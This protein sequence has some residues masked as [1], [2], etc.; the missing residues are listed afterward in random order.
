[1][2][3]T[4]LEQ[5]M[6][7]LVN[8]ARMD[9]MGDA[10]RYISGYAPLTSAQSNIQSAL[11]YFGVNGSQLLAAYQ[12]LVPVQP[13]AFNDKLATAARAHSSAMLAAGTQAHQLPGEA[14]LGQRAT[15][16]GY[17]WRAL[18]E[19]VYAYAED[20]LFGHAGFMVDWGGSAATG[21]MQSPPGHRMNI[22]GA[23]FREVGV[24]VVTGGVP[25]GVGPNLVTE[26]FGSAG[27]QGALILGVAYSD[28]N[29][30]GFYEP[31]EGLAG[32]IATVGADQAQSGDSGG[33]TLTS[34]L[35]GQQYVTLSG[36]GLAGSVVVRV[37][38]SD[39]SGAGQNV[40][41]DVVDGTTLKVS[42]SAVVIGAVQTVRALG[43]QA[44]SISLGDGVGR[45]LVGNAGG[46]TLTG[47][48]G[49]DTILGGAGDDTIDG[50]TGSNSLDGG[51]GTNTAV[52]S[53]ASSAGTVARSGTSWVVTGPG[54]RDVL[55]NFAAFRFTDQ[56]LSDLSVIPLVGSSF[57]DGPGN[58]TYRG[59]GTQTVLTINETRRGD[60]FTLLADGGLQ[61]GHAGQVDTAY[62]IQ[63]IAFIDGRVVLDP[64]DP[65]AQVTRLYQ[66]ALA[67]G[68]DAAGLVLWVAQLQ[69]GVPLSAL[70]DGFLGS[71]EFIARFGAN[72]ANVDF[73]ARLY[74]NVL[75]RAGED[76]GLAFWTG[77]LDRGAA[78]RAQTLA[79]FAESSEN[80]AGTAGLVAQGIWVPSGTAAQVAR[81]YDAALG[82][83]PDAAGLGYW[84]RA[85]DAGSAT[86]AGLA[87][88]FVASTEFVAKYGALS[89][90]AFVSAIYQN[91]LGRPSDAS[92][93]AYWS[94]QLGR[95]ATRAS[96][97]VG[98]SEST[99]HQARTA[100][101]VLSGDPAQYGIR[102]A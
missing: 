13:V 32:L 52:F 44:L 33:Y 77:D 74:K 68:P 22:M 18:G 81:L 26:D 28:T 19:N 53:F 66:A 89:D 17:S 4:A 49:D 91:T 88:S 45:T 71:S 72:L 64:S 42:A 78:T 36:G 41:L 1:M 7:E 48:A 92:G 100:G 37:A 27:T 101:N 23:S 21:G 9:P 69:Q 25:G 90:S 47:G 29:R 63:Q 46:D 60:T 79:Q 35:T 62:G 82:R 87:A 16:A 31:G 99:E 85:I 50:G 57:L 20:M 73:V 54:T 93:L 97:V 34:A 75:G 11:T 2:P 40:K 98:F 80:K 10:A 56:T 30:D 76:S 43:V 70:A 86:L 12:A 58:Q 5:Y 65:A 39:G 3:S 95:G 61:V 51:G 24:G 14:E 96:V 83:L 6:L 102:V 38:L 15:N 94:D 67:R 84:T 55:S 8:D 59:T